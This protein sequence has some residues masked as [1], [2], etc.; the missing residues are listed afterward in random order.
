M[1]WLP[2]PFGLVKHS[3][4]WNVEQAIISTCPHI[5]GGRGPAGPL[6]FCAAHD[7][8]P[9]FYQ[10]L[11]FIGKLR[12]IQQRLRHADAPRVADLDDASLRG[13]M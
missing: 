3:G 11:H 8:T 12:L 10:E 6:A 1:P 2:L 5:A 9:G 4:A 13:H 7:E